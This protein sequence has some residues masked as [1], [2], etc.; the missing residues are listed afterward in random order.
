MLDGPAIEKGLAFE[1]AFPQSALRLPVF[2]LQARAWRDRGDARRAI[3]A[4]AAGLVI[5][6]DYVPLLVD[7]ADLFA[8]GG[9]PELERASAAA[10]RALLLLETARAPARIPADAWAVAVARLRARAHSALGLVRFKQEDSAGARREFEAALAQG[11]AEENPAIH[12][13]LGRLLASIGPKAEARRHLEA[14]AL[15]G[16][17]PLRER[18]LAALAELPHE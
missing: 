5:A 7:L 18:A 12:Y 4:A 15:S 14:A 17:K 1:R 16:N 6:P 2:E 13:R 10:A 8:N 3:A 11:A 9:S